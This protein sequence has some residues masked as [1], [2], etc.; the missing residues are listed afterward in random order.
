MAPSGGAAK[1]G[2]KLLRDVTL[3]DKT[4]MGNRGVAGSPFRLQ[5]QLRFDEADIP[6][7]VNGEE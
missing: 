4:F 7:V 2:D 1:T 3:E 5:A 6:G